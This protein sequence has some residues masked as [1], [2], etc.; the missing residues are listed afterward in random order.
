MLSVRDMFGT[1]ICTN[2]HNHE[3][4]CAESSKVNHC[5]S[6]TF[7]EIIGIGTSCTYPVGEGC[8]HISCNDEEGEVLVKECGGK[9]DEEEADC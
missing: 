1:G 9:D 4:P 7:H 5:I 3:E 8:K 2:A 6:C